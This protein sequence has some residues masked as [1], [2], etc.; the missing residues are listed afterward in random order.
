MPVKLSADV[1]S[2]TFDSA[3]NTIE[4]VGYTG[5]R[6]MRYSWFSD[7]FELAFEMTEDAVDL[8]SLNAKAPLLNSHR[9]ADVENVLGVIVPGSARL[10]GGKLLAKVKLSR[11][12]AVAGT[13]QDI[14]DGILAK[15]SMGSTILRQTI[16][17]REGEP[18]LHTATSWRPEELSVVPVPADFGAQILAA[19]EPPAEEPKDEEPETPA[20]PAAA[21]ASRED[22][23]SKPIDLAAEAVIAERARVAGIKTT[24]RKLG[25]STEDPKVVELTDGDTELGPAREILIDL[26]AAK[27][28]ATPTSSGHSAGTRIETAHEDQLADGIGNMLLHRAD[29]SVP[30][31]DAGR[32]F[33]GF[34][35]LE[36]ARE[37]LRQVGRDHTGS[38]NEVAGRAMLAH[39][40]SDFPLI[41]AQTGSQ[42]LQKA[43]TEAPIT[44]PLWT[45]RDDLP[46]FKTADRNRLGEM[47]DLIAVPEGTEFQEVTISEERE[48]WNL[49]TYGGIFCATKRTIIN[50]GLRAFLRLFQLFGNAAR[51][52]EEAVVVAIL[53][54]NAAMADAVDLFHADHSNYIASGAGGPPSTA[55]EVAATR[56]LLQKQT[57]VDS[58]VRIGVDARWILCPVDLQNGAEQLFAPGYTP[59]AASSAVTPQ[60]R[61]RFGGGVLGIA[62]LTDATK[63]YMAAD[64][65]Q[66]P[67]IV[68]GRLIGEAGPVISTKTDFKTGNVLTKVE[69]NFGAKAEDWRGLVLN[70]GA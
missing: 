55:A 38:P 3:E 42:M 47:P 5:A 36:L 20:Q 21:A 56:L 57:G 11:R 41:L 7:P 6:V 50:D 15:I 59:T 30:L 37:W 67:G 48:Q 26:H 33:A 63:W 12:P 13:V 51:R 22:L 25:M 9:S 39:S 70:D 65:A 40:T 27:A 32:H 54:A 10:E 17:E 68:H 31:T 64:P 35:D 2:E 18:D 45:A 29:P 44:Y 46:D 69:N 43:Y 28:D 58:S 49:E 62:A 16:E 66:Q 61:A 23:M 52:K 8:E 60:M 14:K 1:Q 4:V 53:T 24:A 34:R 19:E